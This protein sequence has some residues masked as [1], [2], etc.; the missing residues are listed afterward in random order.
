[1]TNLPTSPYMYKEFKETNSTPNIP[2]IANS[3]IKGCQHI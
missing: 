2:T 1:M 3:G